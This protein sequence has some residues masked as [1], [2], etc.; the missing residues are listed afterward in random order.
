MKRLII[1]LIFTGL[2]VFPNLISAQIDAHKDRKMAIYLTGEDSDENYQA[3]ITSLKQIV[4]VSGVPSIITSDLNECLDYGMI[5]FGNLVFENALSE[6][7][8]ESLKTYVTNGGTIVFPGLT[9]PGLYDLAG[10]EDS[11][12]R[13]NRL[14]F[15]FKSSQTD[16]EL[17]WIDEAYEREIKLGGMNTPV[18]TQL[19]VIL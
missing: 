2:F 14:F 4:A 5:L 3:N 9:E 16:R 13:N 6:S 8:I 10:I 12:V 18:Y 17:R 7:E 19:L 11:K 15:S 1:T